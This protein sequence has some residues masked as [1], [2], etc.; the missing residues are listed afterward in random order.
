LTD[1]SHGVKIQDAQ[2]FTGCNLAG[3]KEKVRKS[4]QLSVVS[5]PDL[6]GIAES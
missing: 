1:Y 2:K 5:R 4:R 6:I 3:K